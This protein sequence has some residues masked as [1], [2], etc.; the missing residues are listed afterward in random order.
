[1]VNKPINHVPTIEIPVWKWNALK[2]V[3]AQNAELL[4]VLEGML[5]VISPT[6]FYSHR[7]QAAVKIIAKTKGGE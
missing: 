7:V 5:E 1:M 3:E 6:L 2:K 4:A